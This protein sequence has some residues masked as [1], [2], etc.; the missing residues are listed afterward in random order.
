M[1]SAWR[2]GPRTGKGEEEE[3]EREADA[4]VPHASKRKE[5]GNDVAW[6]W[7]AF[8]EL[9]GWASCGFYGLGL[10]LRLVVSKYLNIGFEMLFEFELHSNSNFTQISSK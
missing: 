7:A 2:R 8:I 9:L 6:C 5:E 3:E 1:V 4:W 10:Q